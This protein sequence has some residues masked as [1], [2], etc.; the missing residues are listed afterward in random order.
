MSK[1]VEAEAIEAARAALLERL[2]RLLPGPGVLSVEPT[3]LGLHGMVVFS[4]RRDNRGGVVNLWVTVSGDAETLADS[5]VQELQ[6]TQIHALEAP[7]GK[8]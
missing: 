4:C 3:V 8:A 5:A 6:A 7:R 1:L 2:Q